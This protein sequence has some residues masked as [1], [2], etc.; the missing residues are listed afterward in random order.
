ML[1][2]AVVAIALAAV[3]FLFGVKPQ[4]AQAQDAA[5]QKV[6]AEAQL[7]QTELQ[8]GRLEKDYSSIGQL[9]AQL[10]ALRKSVPGSVEATDF[11]RQLTAQ[12]SAAQVTVTSINVGATTAYAPTAVAHTAATP[13]APAATPVPTATPAAGAAAST[14]QTAPV[15]ANVPAVAPAV[16]ADPSI[17]AANFVLVP[18]AISATGSYDQLMQF[19]KSLQNAG[20]RLYL[21]DK[22]DAKAGVSSTGSAATSAGANTATISGYIYVLVGN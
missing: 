7:Q 22:I 6:Q 20:P 11:I 10:A 3:A 17:T 1:G 15:A 9:T 19:T 12:A 2:G 14:A 8:L 16:G 13:A 18:V 4:L 5:D 21:I